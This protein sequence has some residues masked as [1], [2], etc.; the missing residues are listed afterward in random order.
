MTTRRRFL[1]ATA[2][3]AAA[4]TVPALAQ[5]G[6]AAPLPRNGN[7]SSRYRP[8]G[9]LGMGGT[10]VGSNHFRTPAEQ[11]AATLQA[12]WDEGV[13]YFDTSPWYGLGLS[14]R[15]FGTFFDDKPRDEWTLSTK[16]GRVLVPDASVAGTK[17]G[18]WAQVPPMRHEYDYSA[19]GTRRSIEQSLQRTGLAQIDIVFVHDLSPDNA[20]LGED[21]TEHFEIAAKGAFPELTRMREEGLIKAW[22]MGVNTIEPALRAFE[23]ADPDIMLSATQYSLVKHRDALNRLMPVVEER[24]ASV[25]V[26][27][28][29]NDGFLAGKERFN[30]GPVP[31]EMRV[32]RARIAAL[33]QEHGTDLRTAALHFA[34]AHPAVSAIIPGARSATQAVQNAN[35]LR[36]RIDGAFWNALRSERLI[37]ENAPIPA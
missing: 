21:W 14:E 30:Y 12:A 26:G 24:G 23:V 28:P 32:K 7:E 25:V 37:E 33:A 15:R 1:G 17:V 13:R 9:R 22:G 19:E 29:L 3:I 10:Q 34:L 36:S 31:E 6:G 11:A 16:V 4:L 20:D 27:A 2:G 35:S 18:N 8:E 5:R